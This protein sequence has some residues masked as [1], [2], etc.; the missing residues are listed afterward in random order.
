MT[1]ILTGNAWSETEDYLRDLLPQAIRAGDREASGLAAGALALLAFE[2][3]R[4]RE[5]ARWM[6]EADPHLSEQDLIGRLVHMRA[7]RVGVAASTNN[8]SAAVAALER[9]EAALGG[10]DPS[11]IQRM[12]VIRAR[13]WV[14]AARSRAE[15]LTIMRAGADLMA[16][17][18]PVHAAH[19]AYEALRLG[20]N[21]AD[22]LEA[23]AKR[24]ETRIVAA[25]AAH[26]RARAGHDGGA[27][28]AA[29]DELSAI[30]ANH[31]AMEAAVDAATAFRN[32]GREDSA[33]RAATRAR[34][35]HSWLQDVPPPALEGPVVELTPRER[36]LTELAASGLSN[37]EIAERLVLS[38]R[39]V[40]AH[41]YS[42]M[43]KL[44]VS[45]RQEL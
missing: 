45:S 5:S 31:Y 10:R 26:A 43:R 7:I 32:A 14:A 24:G 29:A 21:V 4:Y 23:L 28:L 19:L 30:G 9:M 39:T 44:G 33:R 13:G 34:E 35:L 18:M 6:A 41:L 17:P 3:G 42:A 15:A 36:Q 11:P 16:E 25:F 20:A 1:T 12:H 38:V 22:E 40:E 27:L 37:P 8:P 2:R